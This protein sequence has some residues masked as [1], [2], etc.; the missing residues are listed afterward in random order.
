MDDVLAELDKAKVS[1]AAKYSLSNDD[2]FLM[3]N[4][5]NL[6]TKAQKI[7]YPVNSKQ[8]LN[9]KFIKKAMNKQNISKLSGSSIAVDW[10]FNLN[11]EIP[12]QQIFSQLIVLISF[13][14]A[15]VMN[16]QKVVSF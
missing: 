3:T 9:V 8:K 14:D 4:S 7:N 2:E 6:S 11:T 10:P 15:G 1:D 16:I 13:I 12:I 5:S